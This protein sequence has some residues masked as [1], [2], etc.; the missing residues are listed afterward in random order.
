MVSEHI[1][2]NKLAFGLMNQNFV[3]HEACYRSFI[4]LSLF[5]GSTNLK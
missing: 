3:I 1:D 2:C 4:L 5:A